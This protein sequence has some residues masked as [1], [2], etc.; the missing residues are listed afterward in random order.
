M[1]LSK[2]TADVIV[3]TVATDGAC[4]RAITPNPALDRLGDLQ[5]PLTSTFLEF[6]GTAGAVRNFAM[7]M[8]LK[9]PGDPVFDE[10][11]CLGI[12]AVT[13]KAIHRAM[14]AGKLPAIRSCSGVHRRHWGVEHEATWL[15][16]AD[17]SEY[18]FDWHATL[19]PRD[20]RISKLD[21]WMAATNAINYVFF[22]GFR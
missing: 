16:A 19:K 21:D 4:Q 8:A 6:T 5:N 7:I 20:P 12:T 10:R 22:K 17:D 11:I 15:R 1:A 14:R 18:V 13:V 2:S 3:E 9:G